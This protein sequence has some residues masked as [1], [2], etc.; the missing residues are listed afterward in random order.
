MSST[1]NSG[2]KLSYFFYILTVCI[3]GAVMRASGFLSGLLT[4]LVLC[5]IGAA[6]SYLLHSG[7]RKEARENEVSAQALQ[8]SDEE[9]QLRVDNAAAAVAALE[10]DEAMMAQL[11]EKL[12]IVSDDAVARQY[13]NVLTGQLVLSAVQHPEAAE[14]FRLEYIRRLFKLHVP[15]AKACYYYDIEAARVNRQ[16]ARLEKFNYLRDTCFDLQEPQFE[17]SLND[18]IRA[19]YFLLSEAVNLHV[20]AIHLLSRNS[21]VPDEVLAELKRFA[22]TRGERGSFMCNLT[23]HYLDEGVLTRSELVT[24]MDAEEDLLESVR[25][26]NIMCEHPYLNT[27]EP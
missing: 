16:L 8:I 22:A 19:D 7:E 20:Q 13:Q 6:V 15:L 11:T 17:Q 1:S 26:G 10:A 24:Y 5:V 25:Y 4:A 9:R 2:G 14:G 12:T 3:S 21:T 23:Q 27:E 18:F